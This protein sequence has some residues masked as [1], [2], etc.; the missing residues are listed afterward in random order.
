[1]K[2]TKNKLRFGDIIADSYY[3]EKNSGH[4]VIFC[5][6]IPGTSSYPDIAEKYAAA[7]FIFI[8]PKYIGS[9]ESYGRFSVEGCKN[10]IIDFIVGLQQ[11]QVK[12]IF[13]DSFEV[14]INRI[15]L[16]GHSF[17]G[18]VAL[19]AGAELANVGIIALAPVMDFGKQGNG[20][21]PEEKMNWLGDFISAGFEN[22]YRGFDRESWR[23]FCLNG[24]GLNVSEYIDKLRSREI[25]LIHG[26]SDTSVNFNRSREFA[27]E[28]KA[29]GGRI[30]Y[31][32]TDDDHGGVKLSSFE[33][34]VSW[35]NKS[36]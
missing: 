32:E 35:I 31:V 27:N 18:S 15:Y 2:I 14:V 12:T 22:V 11:K 29:R 1:M 36:A 34:N 24:H 21:Y 5:A 13:G 20:E 4:A 6:G 9:W 7:G 8:Q 23:V 33:K 17:G 26:R 28:L 3:Q 30:E 16:F 10:T 19:S 25:L